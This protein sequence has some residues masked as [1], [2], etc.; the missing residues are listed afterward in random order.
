LLDCIYIIGGY[1]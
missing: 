1:S